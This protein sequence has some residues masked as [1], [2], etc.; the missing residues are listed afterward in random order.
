[1]ILRII[2]T[3]KVL[4]DG[5]VDRV[6][7]PGSC[8]PFTVLDRHAPLISTLTEGEIVYVVNGVEKRIVVEGGIAEVRD[9][10]VAVCVN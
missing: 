8:G 4:F 7:L 5:P 9:N 10:W 6:T 3:E 1:M 2:S